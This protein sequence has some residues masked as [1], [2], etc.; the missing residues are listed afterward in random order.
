MRTIML[1]NEAERLNVPLDA[2]KKT[3][4]RAISKGEIQ[5]IIDSQNEELIRYELEELDGL[6][7][8]LRSKRVRLRDLAEE[9]NLKV[10]Q[11]RL[12]IDKLM[13]EGRIQGE[14]A[15]DGS[16]VSQTI[17]KESIIDDAEKNHI[18]ILLHK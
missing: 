14:Y 2:V 13:E 9:M 12:I 4:A 7:E 17:I 11:S 3:L 16:F 1:R 5:G 18:R 15:S 10:E 6:S 8:K